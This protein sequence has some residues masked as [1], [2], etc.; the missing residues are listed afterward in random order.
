MIF[1]YHFLPISMLE[2]PSF[3]D[4]FQQEKNAYSYTYTLLLEIV[5]E[6]VF[7]LRNHTMHE[8]PAFQL[9]KN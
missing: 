2:E 9:D 5:Q 1:S 6:M 4:F 3:P 8:Y 7:S